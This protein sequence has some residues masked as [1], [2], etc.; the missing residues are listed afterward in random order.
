MDKVRKDLARQ[1]ADLRGGLWALRGN[2]WTRNGEQQQRRSQ[3]MAA[4]PALGRA[5]ALREYLQDAL[6][7][8]EQAQ[9]EGWLAWAERSRLTAFR[10]L[11]RTLKRHRDGVLAYMETKL[12]NGL[13]EAIN[14]LLQLAKRI[15][16]GFRNF[17]YFRLAAYL[18]A[19][20][21]NL[22]TPRLLPT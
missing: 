18:K 15:A 22:Q 20:G 11:A 2:G 7:S 10:D 6:A 4:Y 17:H 14:G 16:R 19:G 13:M 21:L 8:G 3:L 12:T 9:L 5:V 1:G